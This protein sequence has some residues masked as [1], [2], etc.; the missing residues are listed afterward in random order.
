MID[1]A[2]ET[3]PF[4]RERIER[5]N[6]DQIGV[7]GIFRDNTCIYVGRGDIRTE[8]M[9]Y[10]RGENPRITDESPTHY[11]ALVTSGDE[12]IERLLITWYQPIANQM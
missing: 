6:P 8:L 5:L 7:Y 11:R 9:R 3:F 2:D 10:V 1:F 12:R 4:T